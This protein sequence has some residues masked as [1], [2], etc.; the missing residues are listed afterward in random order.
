MRSSAFTDTVII[1]Q[2][3]NA[4]HGPDV[5]PKFCLQHLLHTG[6]ILE[7]LYRFA[8]T[9]LKICC[10]EMQFNLRTFILFLRLIASSFLKNCST[11]MHVYCNES[12]PLSACCMI[13]NVSFQNCLSEHDTTCD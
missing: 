9:H 13:N 1:Y 4:R 6:I 10:K 7:N 2:K 11:D 8:L 5:F 12:L 3:Y